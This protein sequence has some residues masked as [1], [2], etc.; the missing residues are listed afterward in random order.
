MKPAVAYTLVTNLIVCDAV[1]CP[2][3]AIKSVLL[4]WDHEMDYCHQSPRVL[5]QTETLL[6]LDTIPWPSQEEKALLVGMK[7]GQIVIKSAALSARVC[8]GP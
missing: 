8:S 5:D 6:K 4:L 7:V 2:E 1:S 3:E